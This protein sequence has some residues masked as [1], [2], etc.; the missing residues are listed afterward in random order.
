M[1]ECGVDVLSSRILLR[2]S[3][4]DRNHRFHRDLPGLVRDSPQLHHSSTW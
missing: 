2:T 3:N 1:L 4:L